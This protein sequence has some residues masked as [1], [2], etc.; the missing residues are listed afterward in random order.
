MNWLLFH[1]CLSD[2]PRKPFCPLPLTA[3]RPPQG[4]QTSRPP[5]PCMLT[6]GGME[7][8]VQKWKQQEEESCKGERYEG[9]GASG[10]REQV[11]GG[12]YLRRGGVW[13]PSQRCSWALACTWLPLV[14]AYHG[15]HSLCVGRRLLITSLCN[16]RVMKNISVDWFYQFHI[17]LEAFVKFLSDNCIFVMLLK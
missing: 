17:A 8:F 7:A 14:G 13:T 3:A 4:G 11:V 6:F 2:V 1:I 16:W 10:E 9:G 5:T 15:S 12:P